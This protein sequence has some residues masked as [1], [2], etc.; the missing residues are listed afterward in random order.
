MSW[1]TAAGTLRVQYLKSRRVLRLATGED[2]T[3]AVEIPLE[4]FCA[5][6][7]ID[8][9]QLAPPCHYLLSLMWAGLGTARHTTSPPP[10]RT[11]TAPAARSVPS[12]SSTPT[13][14]TGLS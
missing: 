5:G 14:P 10:S 9:A 11:R 2:V 4:E 6:L 13:Q 7:G 12:A 1:A 8:V 3:T